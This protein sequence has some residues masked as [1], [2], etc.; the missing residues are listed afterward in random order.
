MVIERERERRGGGGREGEKTWTVHVF[1]YEYAYVLVYIFMYLS[2]YTYLYLSICVQ[3]CFKDIKRPVYVC[4]YLALYVQCL[5]VSCLAW[6]KCLI[7]LRECITYLVP[8][9]TECK[10]YLVP[11]PAGAPR[12]ITSYTA[13]LQSLS[14]W[15]FILN[16]YTF[17]TQVWFAIL[18]VSSL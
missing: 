9:L 1:V 7:T 10:I 18:C 12:G 13:S 4:E 2:T 8:S 5:T 3:A 15:H 6:S 17:K 11:Y 16:L 14:R